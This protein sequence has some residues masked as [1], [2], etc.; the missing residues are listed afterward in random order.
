MCQT[1][2]IGTDFSVLKI[3]AVVQIVYSIFN[4]SLHSEN[5]IHTTL[6]KHYVNKK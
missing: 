3:L 5:Y 2:N 4:V 6:G 1:S